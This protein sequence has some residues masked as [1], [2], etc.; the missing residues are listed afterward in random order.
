MSLP[1]GA[2]HLDLAHCGALAGCVGSKLHSQSIASDENLPCISGD[3]LLY[4][5]KYRY[6]YIYT[7]F[8]KRERESDMPKGV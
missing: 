6:I 5:H 1:G 2:W 3:V 4:V 7:I 8:K